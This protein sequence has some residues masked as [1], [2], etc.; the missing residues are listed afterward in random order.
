[1]GELLAQVLARENPKTA[2]K[3]VV[4]N[5]G[6]SGV[7]GVEVQD[8]AAYLKAF[9]PQVKHEVSTGQYR[10]KPVLGVEIPKPSGGKRL[11]GIPTVLDRMLQQALHQVLSLLWEEDFSVHSYGF[12]PGRKAQQAV[13]QGLAYINEGYQEVIDL[14][15]KSFFDRVNHDKLMA[16]IRVKVKD[17][18]LLR[19]IRRYLQ[20]GLML[21]GIEQA[22]GE[23]TPQG[24]PLSP[25]L[26]NILLNELD[27]E[28]EK[29]GHRFVRYADDISIYVRSRVAAKR[30][31]GS[32]R[33]FLENKLLLEVNQKKTRIC[34]PVKLTLLGYGFVSVYKKGVKGQYRLRV[35]PASMK[36][37]KLKLKGLTRK[38]RP[39]S[40]TDRI[41]QINRLKKGW[42]QYFKYAHTYEK[43]KQLD[44]WVRNRLRYC[45]WKHW[46]KPE[47]RRRSFI[48]LGV[49]HGQAYAWS[50]SRMGGWAIAQSPMM[51]TTVTVERLKQRGYLPFVEYYL[52]IRVV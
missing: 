32:I 2:Y 24:G 45:I 23:G 38:T 29:R 20:S 49:S 1:M 16:L 15:L 40:L 27:Q 11:L 52:S 36:R 22:R 17:K 25:L 51:R 33:R 14:D 37:L 30:V 31:L 35:A 5:K 7:D 39:I 50:R 46:K 48:G 42:L 6:S 3:R 21:G 9:W 28:L 47:K 10:P 43:L 34:R 8:L 44:G 19:L 18:F 13:L 4:R 41:G 12:R 26:S